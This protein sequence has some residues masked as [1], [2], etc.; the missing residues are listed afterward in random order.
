V[1]KG[2]SCGEKVGLLTIGMSV[3]KEE[4]KDTEVGEKKGRRRWIEFDLIV[5]QGKTVLHR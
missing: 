2:V 3:T 5:E 4:E 1:V